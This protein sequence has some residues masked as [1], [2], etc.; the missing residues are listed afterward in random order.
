MYS[1]GSISFRQAVSYPV[2]E[3]RVNDKLYLA[4][5]DYMMTNVAA[6]FQKVEIQYDPQNPEISFIDGKRTR[7]LSIAECDK[8]ASED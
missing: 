1:N 3:Y 2:Y 7:I 6:S 5:H 4:E 8:E